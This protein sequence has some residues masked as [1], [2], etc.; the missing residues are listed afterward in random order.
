MVEEKAGQQLDID[1]TLKELVDKF[2]QEATGLISSFNGRNQ[3]SIRALRSK[4]SRQ[5]LKGAYSF[6]TDSSLPFIRS[7]RVYGP[8]ADVAKEYQLTAF[9]SDGT[10]RRSVKFYG[11][12]AGTYAYA[13]IYKAISGFELVPKGKRSSVEVSKIEATGHHFSALEKAGEDLRKI[14][15]AK[16]SIEAYSQQV[17]EEVAALL[18]KKS[19]LTDEISRLSVEHDEAASE[20]VTVAEELSKVK[21]EISLEAA[22]REKLNSENRTSQNSLAQLEVKIKSIN[23]EVSKKDLELRQLT[24]KRRLISDEFS[25]FVDEGR[26]QARVYGWISIVPAMMAAVALGFLLYGGWTFAKLIVATPTQAYAYFIQRLP[27]TA[28]TVAIVGMLLEL[29]RQIVKK[30][31][32]IHED[33]LALARLLVIARDATYASAADL[34]MSEEQIFAERMKVKMVLLKAHLGIQNSP[35]NTFSEAAD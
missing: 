35:S 11:S 17:K 18:A 20:S 24:D 12:R 14:L 5:T 9:L 7:I 21:A 1:A 8:A 13:P 25:S 29:L 22:S 23:T 30:V 10:E 2:P 15:E 31:M 33:R 6:E 28:A 3:K 26:V 19:D 32:K 27:Y 16:D 34:E 4:D